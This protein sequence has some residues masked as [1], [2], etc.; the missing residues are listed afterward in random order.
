MVQWFN[1]YININNS[2]NKQ[3]DDGYKCNIHV[4]GTH[5]P[6]R[7]GYSAI[8]SSLMRSFNGPKMITGRV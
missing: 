7:S 4:R 2:L 8:K 5:D 3:C 6:K 1:D